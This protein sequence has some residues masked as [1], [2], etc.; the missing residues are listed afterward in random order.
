MELAA[1]HC[2]LRHLCWWLWGSCRVISWEPPS[3]HVS[4][5]YSRNIS[6]WWSSCR[7]VSLVLLA[8]GPMIPDY[9]PSFLRIQSQ[10]RPFSA[11]SV[12]SL[13]ADL[14][15]HL[16]CPW[17]R[18]ASGP[19]CPTSLD[20][21][22]P[23]PHALGVLDRPWAPCFTKWMSISDWNKLDLF[24][25]SLCASRKSAIWARPGRGTICTSP[26]LA[27]TC[28]TRGC[29]ADLGWGSRTA[30]SSPLYTFEALIDCTP[31]H[32]QSY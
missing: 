3:T 19:R 15:W 29:D 20:S 5:H 2:C 11:S 7:D 16:W 12:T 14:T 24:T 30:N 8:V 27:L 22:P 31:K 18:R 1:W 13:I 32:H 4:L 28:S 26:V 23:G 10:K 21:Q 17:F 6:G 25:S 9:T